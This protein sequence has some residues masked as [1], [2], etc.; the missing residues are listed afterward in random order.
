MLATQYPSIR[1]R[2]NAE[3]VLIDENMC[4]AMQ[5]GRG[6]YIFPLGDD[7]SLHEEALVLIIDELSHNPDMLSLGW[8]GIGSDGTLILDR[9]YLENGFG[10]RFYDP[11]SALLKLGVQHF[12]SFV[13]KRNVI[14]FETINH[15]SGTYHA[16]LGVVWEG[17]S[18][19]FIEKGSVVIHCSAKPLVY[20]DC[21]GE[22]SWSSQ[23]NEVLFCKVPQYLMLLPEGLWTEARFLRDDWLRCHVD[24]LNFIG[25]RRRK[26][27]SRTN[28]REVQAFLDKKRARQIAIMMWI[29]RPLLKICCSLIKRVRRLQTMLTI[30]QIS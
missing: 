1:Y 3:T 13:I 7:D 2:V 14:A 15:Y 21:E 26:Q 6:I 22:K 29:P 25:M 27:L 8:Q 4:L 17:L 16:Y 24:I 19:K 28:Y 12:S 30:L 23:R 11:K 10:L 5:M 20:V 9:Q 18:K